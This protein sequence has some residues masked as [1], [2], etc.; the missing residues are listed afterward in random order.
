MNALTS[1]DC[2][3]AVPIDVEHVAPDTIVARIRPDLGDPVF[4][5][6][7]PGFPLLPGVHIFEFV[8]RAVRAAAPEL[9][10]A[11]IVSC[12]FLLPFRGDDE[13]VVTIRRSGDLWRGEVAAAAV[14]VAEVLL[15]YASEE[16]AP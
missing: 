1:A 5:G 16:C 14:P 10:L 13:L 4:A 7:Y 11:E 15:R 12:R 6:H 2:A 3:T 9:A 8:H